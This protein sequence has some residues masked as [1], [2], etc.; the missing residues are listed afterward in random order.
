MTSKPTFMTQ[1]QAEAR[2]RV[3]RHET[4]HYDLSLILDKGTTFRGIVDASFETLDISSEIFIDFRG[5]TVLGLSINGTI[6]DGRDNN[7]SEYFD[8]LFIQLPSK[9]LH[10]NA[11]NLVSIVYENNYADDGLGLHSF[12]DTDGRQYIYSQCESFWCNRIFP[13]FD[14]PD[15]KATM[16][17]QAIHPSD[18][19]A[20][21]N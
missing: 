20:L 17:L 12:T 11:K 15:L 1:A 7:F 9:Y 10:S 16:K 13:N 18:W 6:I 2:S 14:Q 21:S 3:I 5:K 8:G 4:I 19:I